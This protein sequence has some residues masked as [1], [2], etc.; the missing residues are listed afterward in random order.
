M[1]RPSHA[2]GDPPADAEIEQCLH[3]LD[4]AAPKAALQHE[5]VRRVRQELERHH[6]LEDQLQAFEDA[7][8]HAPD[9]MAR[10]DCQF[11]YQYANPAITSWTGL[12][13]EQ[14]I[15]KTH[16]EA[17][18]P[19]ALCELWEAKLREVWDTNREVAFEFPFL[20]LA[21]REQWQQAR[22]VPEVDPA[23][24]RAGSVLSV[25]RDI[26]ELKRIEQAIQQVH[27]Q[28]VGTLDQI[29][30]GFAAFDR[31]WRCLYVNGPAARLLG[32][33]K[34]ELLGHTPW[35]AFPET[36][37]SIYVSQFQRA[38]EEN[39]P[40]QGEVFDPV[41]KAW[42]EC[43]CYPSAEGAVVLFT[44][45]TARKQGEAELRH[46][47]EVA[48]QA[49]LAKDQ[50][51][52]VLSHELRTPLTPVLTAVQIMVRDEHLSAE[53]RE[54][55]RMVERNVA[56]ETR[57]I[58]D[59]LDLTRISR[60]KMPLHRGSVDLH[61]LLRHVL[62][63]CESDLRSKQLPLTVELTAVHHHVEGDAARLQQVFW[64]LLK[65]AIKFTPKGGQIILRS[66]QPRADRVA[67]SVQDTGRGIEPDVLPAIFDPFEKGNPDGQQRLGGL[68]LG[69]SIAKGLVELHEGT[70]TATSGGTGQGATFTV[71][72][73]VSLGAEVTCPHGSSGGRGR[74]SRKSERILL[75]EDNPDTLTVMTRLLTGYGYEV[76]TADSVA[77]AL[78]AAAAARFDLMLCDIGLPDGNGL[79][80]MRQL[81]HQRPLKAIA[82]SGYGMEGDIQ[83]SEAA[84]FRAHLTKPVDVGLLEE[85]LDRVLAAGPSS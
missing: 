1:I 67:V 60:G 30:E 54:T 62:E 43:R 59:L 17:G 61:S 10:F 81:V 34:E 65:N 75:V 49:A 50:F 4:Q 84:G 53:Q 32:K 68:G 3:T 11:R 83:R 57:L 6:R 26:T 56:L 16:G 66:L 37:P 23:T 63:I 33:G 80:L 21:G 85:T 24:G 64:N 7:V 79:D 45:I 36:G 52:A 28:F 44:D 70:L 78:R 20:G 47:K 22:L 14:L 76:I 8:E 19:S 46:A 38:I 72:L 42:H 51:I 9:V 2:P 25:G 58:D 55:I 35:E 18:V 82:L 31:H 12:R 40:V 5:A 73:P 39:T 15:G 71:E 29:S 77:S 13:P 41:S 74:A 69:L 27:R 48:E